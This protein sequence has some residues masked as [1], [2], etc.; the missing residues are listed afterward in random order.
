ML[1]VTDIFATSLIM[2]VGQCQIIALNLLTG[3]ELGNW[4]IYGMYQPDGFKLV[5]INGIQYLLTADEGDIKE[6]EEDKYGF[7]W[8]EAVRGKHFDSGITTNSSVL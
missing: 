4:D 1:V 5:T 8:S 3:I 2:C 7:D 6:Y